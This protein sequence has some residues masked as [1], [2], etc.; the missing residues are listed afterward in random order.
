MNARN[1]LRQH[2]KN[3]R[4]IAYAVFQPVH[5]SELN[6]VEAKLIGAMELQYPILNIKLAKSSAKIVPFDRIV[7][8]QK[9]SSFLSG[10]SNTRSNA[11]QSWPLLE[12]KQQRRFERMKKIPD[13]FLCL[14][15]LKTFIEHCIPEPAMSEVNFW[16]VTNHF[17]APHV[18][19]VNVG[20]QEVFTLW[21]NGQ[22]LLVRFLATEQFSNE[23]EGPMYSTQCYAHFVQI[24]AFAEW[25]NIEKI[26]ACRRLV[27]QLMRHTVPM[28]SGSHCPQLVRAAFDV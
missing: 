15:A 22:N 6:Q 5:N 2:W 28:N 18:F 19:R 25:L 27:V 10:D 14:S 23:A 8:Q 3:Y 7:S 12:S 16:S 4:D 20:Q 1:R 24:E 9:I 26:L 11:W 21:R 17:D 13:Y